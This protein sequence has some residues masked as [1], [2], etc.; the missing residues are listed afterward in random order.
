[1][2]LE[3]T[4]EALDDVAFTIGVPV[5]Q[6]RPGLGLELGNDGGD[7]AAAEVVTDLLPV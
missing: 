2:L 7:T 6:A 5:H 3:A 4:H 1:M